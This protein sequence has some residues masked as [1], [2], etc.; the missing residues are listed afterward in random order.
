MRLALFA[1]ALTLFGC[2]DYQ[3]QR[4]AYA[5]HK[6]RMQEQNERYW[7]DHPPTC[8]QKCSFKHDRCLGLDGPP[9]RD[10]QEW[11]GAKRNAIGDIIPEEPLDEDVC[12]KRV[13]ICLADCPR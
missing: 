1:V 9:N 2:A 7:I 4:A 11:M 6:Q 8:A 10:T 12:A 5:E 13:D 3:R